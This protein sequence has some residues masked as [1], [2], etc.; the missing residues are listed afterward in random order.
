MRRQLHLAFAELGRPPARSFVAHL[1]L[2]WNIPPTFG[3]TSKPVLRLY[4]A[5]LKLLSGRSLP[6]RGTA[7][8]STCMVVHGRA[9]HLSS[10]S[11][12]HL[13]GSHARLPRHTTLGSA[14]LC[15][16]DLVCYGLTRCADVAFENP[17]SRMYLASQICHSLTEQSGGRAVRV[18][19]GWL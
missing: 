2:R 9:W 6:S 15:I 12:R 5:L 11:D 14:D 10:I 17:K 1:R 19:A 7:C 4:T 8:D 18:G 13:C 3:E 16:S